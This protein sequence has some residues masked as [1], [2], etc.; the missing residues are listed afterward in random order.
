MIDEAYTDKELILKSIQN[1][2]FKLTTS[3]DRPVIPSGRP[4]PSNGQS[5]G[6]A[7][8]V[9]WPCYGKY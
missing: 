6:C 3:G 8:I 1:L 9:H 2:I 4:K 7:K 5:T